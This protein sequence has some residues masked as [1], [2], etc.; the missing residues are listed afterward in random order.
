MREKFLSLRDKN[1]PK[2]Q[3]L[4]N[5]LLDP[6]KPSVSRNHGKPNLNSPDNSPYRANEKVS[7]EE[8]GGLDHRSQEECSIVVQVLSFDCLS[9]LCLIKNKFKKFFFDNEIFTKQSEWI[10]IEKVITA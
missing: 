8:A 1:D 4:V 5:F 6:T 2:Y 7:I 9:E 10:K 3:L